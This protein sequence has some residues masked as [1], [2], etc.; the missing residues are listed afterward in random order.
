MFYSY[1]D[2]LKLEKFNKDKPVTEKENARLL[3]EEMVSYSESAVCRR[4]QLLHYFGEEYDDS[5]CR[6]SGMCDNCRYERESFDGQYE[7]Q[8]AIK[9]VEQTEERFGMTHL[10][11]VLRGSQNQ[12]VKSYKS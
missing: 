11:N 9:A 8:L 3:L 7:V 10:I 5:A 6:L 4:K 1:S 2:I 12:Y